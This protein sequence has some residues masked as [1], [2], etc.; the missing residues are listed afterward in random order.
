M[1]IFFL[2][3]TWEEKSHGPEKSIETKED[4]DQSKTTGILQQAEIVQR[5]SDLR[6]TT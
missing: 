4:E 3:V 6:R 5:D 2:K 1:I